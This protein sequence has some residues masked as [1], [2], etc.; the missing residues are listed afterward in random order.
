MPNLFVVNS[1]SDICP[2]LYVTQQSLADSVRALRAYPYSHVTHSFIFE[3]RVI[4]N[5]GDF[6]PTKHAE[7]ALIARV[8][9]ADKS[10]HY[11]YQ[12]FGCLDDLPLEQ[13]I[14]EAQRAIDLISRKLVEL[15]NK[16]KQSLVTIPAP[17]AEPPKG[18]TL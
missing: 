13:G 11:R 2:K 16:Q 18:E 7:L 8:E 9:P 17:T 6:S 1:S 10:E 3:V 4:P 5:T 15:E 12:L 14:H